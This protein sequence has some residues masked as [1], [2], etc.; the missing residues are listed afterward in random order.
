MVILLEEA[1]IKIE[2]LIEMDE[3]GNTTRTDKIIEKGKIPLMFADAL[4]DDYSIEI[5]P[6][7]D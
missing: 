1:Y 2:S 7:E 4:W 3:Y 5:E 6:D